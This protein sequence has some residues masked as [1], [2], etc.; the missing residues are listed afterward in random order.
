GTATGDD[1]VE[2]HLHGGRA[3][4]ASVLAALGKMD[5]LRIAEAGEFTRRAFANGRIDLTQAEGLAD[6]LAAETEAQRRQAI[7][8]AEGGLGRIIAEWRERLLGLAARIEAAIEF[9]DEGDDVP[10]FAAAELA[11]IGDLAGAMTA[12]LEGPPTERLRDGVR[13]VVAGP[14]NAGKSS[15]INYLCERDVAITS[16]IPGTTRDLIEAPLAIAGMPCLLIDSAGLRASADQ[17][18]QIGVARAKGAIEA[19]DLLLWLGPPDQCPDPTRAIVVAAKCDIEKPPVGVD[20]ATSTVTGEGVE[21]LREWLKNRVAALLP[22]ADSVALNARQRE[23]IRHAAR[24]LGEAA[25]L[26]DP[27]LVAEHLRL[28]RLSLD[29]VTGHANVE[30]MLDSLFGRFCIGK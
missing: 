14:V 16:S 8:L 12:A 10:L 5:G 1:V 7:R 21:I 6:L 28:A 27:L 19:A 4:V 15:L 20:V 24:E 13:I 30:D 29:R 9:G 18:E 23:H 11:P 25:A 17:I 3:V 2:L 26:V 22:L